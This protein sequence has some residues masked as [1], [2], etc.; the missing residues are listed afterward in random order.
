MTWNNRHGGSGA[1]LFASV[2][3]INFIEATEQ[4]SEYL[5]SGAK[6][7]NLLGEALRQ[8]FLD[9][10]VALR[11]RQATDSYDSSG[12]T[13]VTAMITPHFIVCANAG[14]SRCVMGTNKATKPLSEDHKPSDDGERRRIEAAG[15]RVQWKRVD[16]DLA[17][18]RAL[19]DFQ[20]KTRSDLGPKEQK[21][22][23]QSNGMMPIFLML[24][25]DV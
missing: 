1:A 11:N 3:M 14:D 16:G 20:Y 23:L 13:S 8:A 9:I 12:C 19:G 15:G 10:D 22:F 2:N 25:F 4:W 24:V 6:D 21:V 5:K 18:S 17:V 7:S